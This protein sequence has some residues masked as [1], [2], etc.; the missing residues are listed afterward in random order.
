[1][2]KVAR[3]ARRL[4]AS[5]RARIPLPPLARTPVGP[6]EHLERAVGGALPRLQPPA[7]FRRDLAHNL[8]LA[9]HDRI[10]GVAVEDVHAFNSTVLFGIMIT[11]VLGSLL[12]GVLVV[13]SA[14][15]RAQ[16]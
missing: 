12:A 2:K 10:A 8:S 13:R 4:W 11:L 5:W 16:R 14:L 7:A 9:A 6:D 15:P 1:M 3:G